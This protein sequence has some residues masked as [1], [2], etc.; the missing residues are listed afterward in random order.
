[1][2]APITVKSECLLLLVKNM[3]ARNATTY[4]WDW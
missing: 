1:M 4:T 3:A 2:A